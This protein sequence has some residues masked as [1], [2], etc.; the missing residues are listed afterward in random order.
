[1]DPI[2]VATAKTTMDAICYNNGVDIVHLQDRG[3]KKKGISLLTTSNDR[4]CP[5]QPEVR[6][7]QEETLYQKE[8]AA[9]PGI[10]NSIVTS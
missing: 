6:N 9:S 3:R 8:A 5:L 7:G 10:R 1:M 4:K 2:A